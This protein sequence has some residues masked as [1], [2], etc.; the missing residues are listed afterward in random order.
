M[1]VTPRFSLDIAYFLRF[2]R[3]GL[4]NEKGNVVRPTLALFKGGGTKMSDNAKPMVDPPSW[5]RKDCHQEWQELCDTLRSS[6]VI[7]LTRLDTWAIGRLAHCQHDLRKAETEVQKH[8]TTIMGCNGTPH[9]SPYA[10][11]RDNLAKE[12]RSLLKLLGLAPTARK[13]RPV[14][15]QF[16]LNDIELRSNDEMQ[17]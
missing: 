17:R 13:P 4:Q 12:Y 16:V 7:D 15:R 14:V 9:I 6:E 3:R 8:G 10:K 1:R 5:L 11:V 2:P